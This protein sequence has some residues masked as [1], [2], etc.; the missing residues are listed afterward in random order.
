MTEPRARLLTQA[1]C[2]ATRSS[3]RRTN[4]K[5]GLVGGVDLCARSHCRRFS[6]P[7]SRSQGTGKWTIQRARE[8][9]ESPPPLMMA[10]LH[11]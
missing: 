8:N 3:Q 11:R 10:D 4:V 6:S 9:D 1:L 2:V 5:F 7:L